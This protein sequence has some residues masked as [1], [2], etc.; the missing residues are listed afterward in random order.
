MEETKVAGSAW[1]RQRWLDQP[2]SAWKRQRW[3]DQPGRDKGGSSK[4]WPIFLD[5]SLH[6]TVYWVMQGAKKSSVHCIGSVLL[7]FSEF[8]YML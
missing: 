6:S 8:V 1:K 5:N 4:C 7:T 3:L 2:G